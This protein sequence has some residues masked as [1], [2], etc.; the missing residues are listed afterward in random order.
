MKGQFIFLDDIRTPLG[1]IHVEIP[2]YPWTIVRGYREFVKVVT[3]YYNTTGSV[4]V[5]VCFD[6]DLSYFAYANEPNY[7]HPNEMTGWHCA[8]WLIEFCDEKNLDFPDYL[9]HSM[10][11]I[12]KQNII[13]LIESYKKSKL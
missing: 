3:D 6:H 2:C 7:D 5:F 11:P 13:S 12:G 1:T 9:V 4:P 8:K 10:N